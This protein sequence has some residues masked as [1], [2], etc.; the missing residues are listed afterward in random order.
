[1]ALY[2]KEEFEP[3]FKNETASVRLAPRLE[4]SAEMLFDRLDCNLE[5]FSYVIVGFW[6]VW[7]FG[8][9]WGRVRRVDDFGLGSLGLGKVDRLEEGSV[10]LGWKLEV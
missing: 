2:S 9:L 5:Q 4:Y 8:H 10:G 3:E 1:M 6:F 7:R